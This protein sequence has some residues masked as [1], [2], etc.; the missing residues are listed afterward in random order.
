MS[1][2]NFDS[3]L[4]VINILLDKKLESFPYSLQTTGTIVE[5]LSSNKYRVQYD[6]GIIEAI[7]L[8]ANSEHLK[9]ETVYLL[10]AN[11]GGTS[12]ILGTEGAGTEEDLSYIFKNL[13]FEFLTENLLGEEKTILQDNENRSAGE[14]F[15]DPKGLSSAGNTFDSTKSFILYAKIQT[16]IKNPTNGK[17][18]FKIFYDNKDELCTVLDSSMMIGNPYKFYSP[19]VQT[20]YFNPPAEAKTITKITFKADSDFISEENSVEATEISLFGAP[21][22]SNFIDSKVTVSFKNASK[23]AFTSECAQV[24]L[25]AELEYNGKRFL[26]LGMEFFWERLDSPT[27]RGQIWAS[28]NQSI[29]KKLGDN[30]YTELIGRVSNE[31]IVEKTSANYFENYYRCKVK[32]L[33]NTKVS[34]PFKVINYEK[35]DFSVSHSFTDKKDTLFA[36]SESI[37]VNIAAKLLKDSEGYS[38]QYS[39]Y[40]KDGES[41]TPLSGGANGSLTIDYKSEMPIGENVYKCVV[42]AVYNKVAVGEKEVEIKFYNYV[43]G[44]DIQTTE[45]VETIYYNAESTNPPEEKP[46][47]EAYPNSESEWKISKPE[48]SNFLFSSERRVL[49]S[50]DADGNYKWIGYGESNASDVQKYSS[51][52]ITINNKNIT[53]YVIDGAGTYIKDP[54]ISKNP[55]AWSEPKCI[56][57]NGGDAEL[58]NQVNIFNQLTQNGTEDGFYWDKDGASRYE[59]TADAAPVTGKIYYTKSGESY[60][61]LEGLASF[62]SSKTYYEYV[63]SHLFINATYVKS[64]TLDVSDKNGTK[65]YAS[66]YRNKVSIGGFE[67]GNNSISSINYNKSRNQGIKIATNEDQEGYFLFTP[68]FKIFQDGNVKVNADNFNIIGNLNLSN[69]VIDLDHPN[70]LQNAHKLVLNTTYSTADTSFGFWSYDEFENSWTYQDRN[71]GDNRVI[72]QITLALEN[73]IYKS[74][75]EETSKSYLT[76]SFEYYYKTSTG[77]DN[78]DIDGILSYVNK[79]NQNTEIFF[80]MSDLQEGSWIKAQCAAEIDPTTINY[81]DGGSPLKIIIESS[82]DEHITKFAIRKIKLEKGSSA[83]EWSINPTEIKGCTIYSGGAIKSFNEGFSVS[84]EGDLEAKSGKIGSLTLSGESLTAPSY[85]FSPDGIE[86]IKGGK[87]LIGDNCRIVASQQGIGGT[88]G[89]WGDNKFKSSITF[90]GSSV[91][92]KD[93]PEYKVVLVVRSTGTYGNPS[94]KFW[95]ET[96]KTDSSESS[97]NVINKRSYNLIY[98]LTTWDTAYTSYKN[99]TLSINPGQSKSEEIQIDQSWSLFDRYLCVA[100]TWDE[101]HGQYA[102]DMGTGGNICLRSGTEY[103]NY[104]K[105]L[106]DKIKDSISTKNIIVLGDLI[107]SADKEFFLGSNEKKWFIHASTVDT[108]DIIYSNDTSDNRYKNSIETLFQKYEIFFDKMKPVRYKYNEGTSDRYHTGYIAQDLVKALEE[109]D[110]TT[111]DFAG[112]VL[113]NPGEE[114]ERWYLRRDE[115]VALNTWQIQK[116]KARVLELEKQIKEIKGYDTKGND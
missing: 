50:I 49:V 111:K 51:A 45:L 85:K 67:V 7:D 6:G 74:F 13:S 11:S 10:I 44:E 4:T 20:L 47:F 18:F 64:K 84:E 56:E 100:A 15:S 95:I 80:S 87:I 8:N 41:Y 5:K 90:G 34:E 66:V 33:G 108:A 68:T 91:E 21:D 61:K 46:T 26:P 42:Q 58:A 104:T 9:D 75:L 2:L 14:I 114:N 82:N 32:Y 24:T 110:L 25:Q 96:R 30:T 17:Y 40:K 76:L 94:G 48:N 78:I 92:Y 102:Q 29:E 71:P 106:E 57:V 23:S 52:T 54:N 88:I 77:T 86:L 22:K 28:L 37:T 3:I 39:W 113:R 73:K 81:L 60:I 19:T 16:I 93:G 101:C 89:A 38:F 65:F 36:S 72:N 69:A 1:N 107:P 55:T 105:V 109:S 112:V 103:S 12:Y 115:F 62:D 98:A 43:L 97:V 83:T 53:Y 99:I 63:N 31:I 79:K 70:Y 116:L 27:L 35:P 59:E